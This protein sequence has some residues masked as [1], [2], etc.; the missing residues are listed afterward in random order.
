MSQ[1]DKDSL[2]RGVL[3]GAWSWSS[4]AGMSVEEFSWFRVC[5]LLLGFQTLLLGWGACKSQVS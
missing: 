3:L 5:P 2:V 4:E 1:A